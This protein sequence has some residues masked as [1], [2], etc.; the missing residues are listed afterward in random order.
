MHAAAADEVIGKVISF[1]G[2]DPTGSISLQRLR[3]MT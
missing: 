3:N 2:G 1:L